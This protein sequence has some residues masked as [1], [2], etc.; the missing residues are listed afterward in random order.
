MLAKY[1]VSE[2]TKRGV[3]GRVDVGVLRRLGA[4][5]PVLHRE[6][7]QLDRPLLR[8]PDRTGPCNQELT[9][10]ATQTSREWYRPNPPLPS[11]K[12]GPRNNVNMQQSALL[13]ALSYVARNKDTFLENYWLKN[14]RAVEKGRTQAPHAWV[15]PGRA[16]PQGRSRRAREPA[17]PPGR[18]GAPRG[19]R[20]HGGPGERG[21]RR[22]R[23]AHGPAVSARWS[24]C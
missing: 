18:R 11:I 7:A 2:M 6:L 22:L 21:R 20:V 8:D 14:K 9:L 23:A 24:T 5:L 13:L 4:Q 15:D 3:P 17:A 1:E 10:G 12:W 16:A 19:R